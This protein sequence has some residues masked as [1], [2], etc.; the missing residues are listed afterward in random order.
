[1]SVED[2][3]WD[4]DRDRDS[5]SIRMLCGVSSG[6]LFV[7]GRLWIL[8]NAPLY[9]TLGG[10][11]R[12]EVRS[13]VFAALCPIRSF[14]ALSS[15]CPSLRFDVHTHC[16][17]SPSV[18]WLCG[19]VVSWNVLYPACSLGIRSVS[20]VR[21]S[22]CAF[23]SAICSRVTFLAVHISCSAM[24][25]SVLSCSCLP[26]SLQCLPTYYPR[27]VPNVHLRRTKCHM[28]AVRQVS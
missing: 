9:A 15:Y 3:D 25:S 20:P 24:C 28:C 19:F 2:R 4:K 26:S 6:R 22:F 23:R 7:P 13:L 14:L 16:Y 11:G 8:E 17:R 21:S 18:P 1:M 27:N 12:L 10:A 5:R